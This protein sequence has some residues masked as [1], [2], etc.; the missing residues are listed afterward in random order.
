LS[1]WTERTVTLH[2]SE[3]GRSAFSKTFEGPSVEV[4]VEWADE[5]G[6]WIFREQVD[7]ATAT[8]MLVRW[9]HFDTAVLDVIL[10]EAEQPKVLGFRR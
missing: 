4:S 8:V 2:L 7:E 1:Y 9:N 6:L 3:S 5:L 10:E